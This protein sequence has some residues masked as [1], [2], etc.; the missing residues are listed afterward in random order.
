MKKRSDSHHKL[1]RILATALLSL[2]LV[3]LISL[4]F[5]IRPAE[6]PAP[7]ESV[8]QPASASVVVPA[9]MTP[10]GGR[11]DQISLATTR[12]PVKEPPAST[13]TSGNADPVATSTMRSTATRSTRLPPRPTR[14]PLPTPSATVTIPAPVPALQVPDSVDVF[15]AVGIDIPLG[16]RNPRT[17]TMILAAVDYDHGTVSLLSLPRDLY[18]YVPNWRF[19]R[20]NTA[21]GQGTF[22]GGA[23]EGMALLG[24]TIL[25][26]F[27]IPIDGYAIIDFGG[28]RKAVDVIGG[29]EVAISCR[30]EDEPHTDGSAA[31]LPVNEEGLV[32]LEPGIRH[33]D[34]DLALWY[35]R[36]RITTNDLDRGRRQQKFIRSFL[37]QALRLGMIAELPTLWGTFSEAIQTDLTLPDIV[38]LAGVAPSAANG[39]LQHIF[40][41]D[42]QIEQW[43]VPESGASV[44]RL[45]RENAATT[46]RRLLTPPPL[47]RSLMPPI[48]VEVRNASGKP[49]ITAVVIDS[50]RAHGF[51]AFAG[52][53]L[54]VQ[55]ESS[56]DLFSENLKGSFDWLL[57]WIADLPRSAVLL[58]TGSQEPFGYRV[59]I[60]S[61]YDP[62]RPELYAPQINLN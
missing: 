26:N 21:F 7:L 9:S 40:M 49:H 53:E 58:H 31:E 47:S 59:T 2:A 10:T 4:A 57:S 16:E 12:T 34:G 41:N 45:N 19:S 17:D 5:L 23:S 18:V 24:E 11:S 61:D 29:V 51:A 48:P 43:T 28:F 13:G 55:A 6:A 22:A 38:G 60:G 3:S 15:L 33:L 14:T 54:P 37:D 50:L 32:V 20:L 56:I 36:S 52:P 25:Y 35:V 1:L 62:C 27:G 39:G 42:S 46:F 8:T 30:L 44:L